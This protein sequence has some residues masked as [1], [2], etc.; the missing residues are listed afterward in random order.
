MKVIRSGSTRWVI[1]TRRYAIKF[2]IP[3][4]WKRFVQGMLSNLTEG[5]WKGY[6]NK[7]L[8]PIKY[9]N[10]FGLVVV[11]TRARPVNHKGLFWIEL[12]RLYTCASN[13]PQKLD[14]EFFEYDALPKNFGYINGQLVKIDYG[15]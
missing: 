10:K 7:F 13:E 9:S 6:Q 14:K 1:L 15:V 12:E 8:C 11:M 2:P 3:T 4:T 5:Q